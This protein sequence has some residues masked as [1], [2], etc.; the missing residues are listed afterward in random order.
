MA[1]LIR[2]SVGG[3]LSLR[4]Y[5]DSRVPVVPLLR[6]LGQ[7]FPVRKPQFSGTWVFP[8]VPVIQIPLQSSDRPA[9]MRTKGLPPKPNQQFYFGLIDLLRLG[10]RTL[11]DYSPI[12]FKFCFYGLQYILIRRYIIGAQ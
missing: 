8:C 11:K 10:R 2:R 3:I 1:T 4:P 7:T 5:G 9:P 6:K 12:K